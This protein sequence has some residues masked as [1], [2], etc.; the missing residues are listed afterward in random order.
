MISILS[1]LILALG[2]T[3]A[4]QADLEAPEGGYSFHGDVDYVQIL[5]Q[6]RRMTSYIET[7]DPQ[8]MVR[9]FTSADASAMRQVGA[10]FIMLE[11]E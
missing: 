9:L 4:P 1:T 3:P 10:E 5:E 2:A 11:A 8:E 6:T 7:P